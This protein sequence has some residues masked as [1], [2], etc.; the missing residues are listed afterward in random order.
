MGRE[1]FSY[2]FHSFLN[3][4]MVLCELCY[5]FSESVILPKQTSTSC[6][7]QYSIEASGYS[8]TG[9]TESGFFENFTLGGNGQKIEC[10]TRRFMIELVVP[11][12]YSC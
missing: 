9:I 4:V 11:L 12:S 1:L 2:R 6:A 7:A 3:F 8:S 10:V 5:S